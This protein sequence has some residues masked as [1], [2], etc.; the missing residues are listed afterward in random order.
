MLQT[1]NQFT[2]IRNRLVS[3]V[4]KLQKIEEKNKGSAVAREIQQVI[5]VLLEEINKLP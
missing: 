2:G 1:N 5:V 4:N 3:L